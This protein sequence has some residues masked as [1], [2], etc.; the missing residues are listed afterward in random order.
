MQEIFAKDGIFHHRYLIKRK[1]GS[2]GMGSVYEAEQTD[3]ARLVALKLLKVELV[4]S[5]EQKE[6]FLRE[7]RALSSLSHKNIM[8]FYSAAIS[9]EGIPYAV[10]ELLDGK[11]LASVLAEENQLS[12]S[13]TV[14]IAAQIADAMEC[15]HK[16]GIIHRDLKPENIILVDTPEK[17][18]VKILDFGLSKIADEGSQ[19]K[20][21][22]TGELIGTVDYM[23]PEQC[24]G[25]HADHR[26]DIYS[27]AC[28]IY[29]CLAGQ[30]LFQA[31]SAIGLI[32]LHANSSI[33]EPLRRIT[34]SAPRSS[35]ELIRE[36]LAKNPDERPQSMSQVLLQLNEART[37]SDYSAI[38]EKRATNSSTGLTIALVMFA[39]VGLAVA[40]ISLNKLRQSNVIIK[41]AVNGS[42]GE[43][44]QVHHTN[45]FL[46]D[47]R[48]EKENLKFATMIAAKYASDKRPDLAKDF[49]E[50]WLIN[51]KLAANLSPEARAAVYTRIS[52]WSSNSEERLKWLEKIRPL[53]LATIAKKRRIG[54]PLTNELTL[55]SERTLLAYNRLIDEAPS[56]KAATEF[57]REGLQFVDTANESSIYVV[58]DFLKKAG[59]TKL[60]S[61]AL[62]KGRAYASRIY[63]EGNSGSTDCLIGALGDLAALEQSNLC[64]KYYLQA[65]KL[66]IL[67][68]ENSVNVYEE[69][70][71]AGMVRRLCLLDHDKS[72]ELMT[73]ETARLS[74]RPD[75]NYLAYTIMAG[76]ANEMMNESKIFLFA[77]KANLD[78]SKSLSDDTRLPVALHLL[79]RAKQNLQK[80]FD[81]GA[82]Q[83]TRALIEHAKFRKLRNKQAKQIYHLLFSLS[84]YC[85]IHPHDEVGAMVEKELKNIPDE[86]K[87]SFD[88]KTYRALINLNGP[89]SREHLKNPVHF[90]KQ[91]LGNTYV[92]AESADNV[93][94]EILEAKSLKDLN[95][96][97]EVPAGLL[98][99]PELVGIYKA[100][101][102]LSYG[103]KLQYTEKNF[104]GAIEA[105]D[106][107]IE[108]LE[109]LPVIFVD[110]VFSYDNQNW[111]L[112]RSNLSKLA[113][114]NA[115]SKAN[116][117]SR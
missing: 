79:I 95:Q 75:G 72:D 21:T 46:I 40:Y 57:V 34:R 56:F 113:C 98:P 106:K 109:R 83:D 14:H 20:L 13:R 107:A 41:T 47:P 90:E 1:I 84:E 53:A 9:D 94:T 2:G 3:A 117:S 19:L 10:C 31:D 66:G 97:L 11:T 55:I 67:S 65:E 64:S 32:H 45:A 70:K 68:L 38:D 103:D 43:T 35:I 6:R 7:F 58:P 63:L 108:V 73:E 71:L 76:C 114:K 29:E 42:A 115:L 52:E 80:K 28:I 37:D 25:K 50:A 51:Y 27:L 18:F 78:W 99:N 77:R 88:E 62:E 54:A 4:S 111:L 5:E 36:M 39:I 81:T 101:I 49:L 74:S 12:W 110:S 82:R 23:S 59:R 116:K 26:S 112:I 24:Q 48:T 61:E 104:K 44:K 87:N 15:A 92:G 33:N 93:R 8:T 69:A 96:Y 102:Y 100:S 30:K 17:D 60:R 105:Y 22:Q 86:Y 16:N 89:S 91:P 85:R